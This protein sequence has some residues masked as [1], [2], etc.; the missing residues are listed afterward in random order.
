[1]VTGLLIVDLYIPQSQ[2]LK[3]K[4]K[5]VKGI[6]DRLR[7]RFNVSYA[8]VSNRDQW[9]RATLGIACVNTDQAHANATLSHAIDLLD[10]VDGAEI[11]ESRMEFV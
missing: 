6:L 2:S 3:N 10:Q 8:E 4:R 7:S 9:Q 11:I 5:I 1:M